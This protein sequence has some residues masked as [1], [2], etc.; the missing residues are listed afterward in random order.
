MKIM[1][2][3]DTHGSL[4]DFQAHAP[5]MRDVDLVIQLG[6]FGFVWDDREVVK[7]LDAILE[8]V[9]V[10]LW[11]IDGNHENFDFLKMLFDLTP[12]DSEPTSMTSR[13]TY[14]PRGYRFELGGV[15]FLAFG[16]ATSIDK[17]RRT[18]FGTWWPQESITDEQVER[19]TDEAV[20]FLLS[21]DVC[22]MTPSLERRLLNPIK[23]ERE[24]ES[25]E[26][27]KRLGEVARR[28]TPKINVHGHYHA[29]YADRA[30]EID[31][32]GLDC[33][34]VHGARLVLDTDMFMRAEH[35]F[36]YQQE[37]SP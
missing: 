37:V 3:G 26:N 27:R 16:G 1:M 35:E 32:I 6:D 15:K 9:D 30:G 34:S 4:R 12:D 2:L 8:E 7:K 20:D 23:P 17:H 10:D 25:I 24:I 18:S 28:V 36:T 19:V 29:Y 5:Y 22:S 21:H 14:L 31:I 13:I 33:G 11:W